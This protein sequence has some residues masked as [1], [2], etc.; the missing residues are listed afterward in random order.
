MNQTHAY[1]I[2]VNRDYGTSQSD[3]GIHVIGIAV[4]HNHAIKVMQDAFRIAKNAFISYM[5]N[6]GNM[7]YRIYDGERI[8]AFDE[9]FDIE[10]RRIEMHIHDDTAP[11]LE[12][13]TVYIEDT[14][15]YGEI[16]E[17]PYHDIPLHDPQTDIYS[18]VGHWDLEALGFELTGKLKNMQ[19]LWIQFWKNPNT[20]EVA[21]RLENS[22][23]CPDRIFSNRDD[24]N[25]WFKTYIRPMHGSDI[26]KI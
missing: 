24:G 18:K 17:Q 4:N 12:S 2:M 15:L 1:A 20:G 8:E 3:R 14:I 16:A 11:Y 13:V 25:L 22:K 10:S 21:I 26:I 6:S 7:A 9:N 23:T 19:N 5:R